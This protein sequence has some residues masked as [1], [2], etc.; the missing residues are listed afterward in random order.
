MGEIYK[1]SNDINDKIYIGKTT[2]TTQIRKKEH[3]LNLN[4]KCAIHKAIIKYGIQ[5]FKWEVIEKDIFDNNLLSERE[6]YW[7]KEYDSYYNGYNMTKGGDGGN[8]L[9]AENLKKWRQNNPEKAKKNIDTLLEWVDNNPEKVKQAN[10][11]A[12]KTRQLKYGKDITKK[13]NQAS[14]KKVKCVETNVVYDS[15]N[16]AGKAMGGAN[17]S[18]IGQVCNGQ[19]KTAYKY[20]WIW[21]QN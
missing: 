11:K 14:K 3:L 17:G 20:H 4:D 21:I 8:G 9:H 19:R 16:D 2:R 5:H 18:H 12:A 7:I 1:I 6:K 10:L 13:A 15:A